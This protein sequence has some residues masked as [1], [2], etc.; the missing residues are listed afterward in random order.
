M[1][2]YRRNTSFVHITP[3]GLSNVFVE[4]LV[5]AVCPY[6]LGVFSSDEIPSNISKEKSACIIVNLNSKR[7]FSLGHFV[8]IILK[9]SYV[10]YIDSFGLPCFVQ[11]V[12]EFLFAC[13]RP[14]FFNDQQVQEESSKFCGLFS[15]LFAIAFDPTRDLKVSLKFSVEDLTKNDMLCHKYLCEIIK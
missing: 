1:N 14:V 7:N 2:N 4:K 3:D 10:L 15:T 5:S 11:T 8:T 13:S 6:F 9:P 12:R